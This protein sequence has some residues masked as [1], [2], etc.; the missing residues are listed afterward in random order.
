MPETPVVALETCQQ[1][2]RNAR[3]PP[4]SEKQAAQRS[5]SSDAHERNTPRQR[6]TQSDSALAVLLAAARRAPARAPARLSPRHHTTKRAEAE[7]GTRLDRRS[8]VVYLSARGHA[9]DERG[10][11]ESQRRAELDVDVCSPCFSKICAHETDETL[12]IHFTRV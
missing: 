6:A 9:R 3:I 1:S 10:E 7:P 5:A 2:K 4:Q 12:R 8:R 11:E